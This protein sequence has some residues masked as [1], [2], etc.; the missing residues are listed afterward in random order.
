LRLY[1]LLTPTGGLGGSHPP[2]SPFPMPPHRWTTF[3]ELEELVGHNINLPPLGASQLGFNVRDRSVFVGNKPVK[4]VPAPPVPPK[5]MPKRARSSKRSGARTPARSLRRRRTTT[6]KRRSGALGNIHSFKGVVNAGVL[7]AIPLATSTNIAGQYILKLTDIPIIA[8][9]GGLS[10]TFNFVRLNKCRLEFMPRYNVNQAPNT[11]AG[12]V[13][14]EPITFMTG[15]SEI[16]LINTASALTVAPSWTSQGGD[17]STVTELTAFTDSTAGP[18]YLRG[19]PGCKETEI[20][21]KHSVWFIPTFYSFLN[22]FQSQGGQNTPSAQ[23]PIYEARK[24]HWINLNYLSQTSG[25]DV[26][27]P[28]PDFY[29]PMY[30]FSNNLAVGQPVVPYYDVKLHY[31]VSFKGTRGVHN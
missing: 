31:S 6:R 22:A 3:E 18:S 1:G 14:G 20:Y 11:G 27:S 30:A 10:N 26:Q 2:S 21:K 23:I 4:L 24:K 29:G 8:S 5:V 13:Q 15:L 7:S 12:S 16:P 17:A 19:M 25:T 28:G 9:G